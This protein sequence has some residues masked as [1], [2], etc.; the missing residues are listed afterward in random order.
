[1][2]AQLCLVGPFVAFDCEFDSPLPASWSTAADSMA[3]A[4]K[5]KITCIGV[6]G[7]H[8]NGVPFR[9]V[10]A[11]TPQGEAR[12]R[13]PLGRRAIEHFLHYLETM[14]DSGYAIVSWGGT[15][16][17]FRVLAAHAARPQVVVDLCK[18]HVDVP[19]AFLCERGIMFGL[20]AASIGTLGY[21]A[22]DGLT[23]SRD[24]P[25]TWA[26]D[27]DKVMAH[28][29]D[30]AVRTANLFV[31]M[32]MHAK[33][34]IPCVT[35]STY[36]VPPPDGT[37]AWL[38]WITRKGEACASWIAYPLRGVLACAALPKPSAGTCAPRTREECCQWFLSA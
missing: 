35:T 1:M 38:K 3:A 37:V 12:R 13:R 6:S 17:D 15:A 26:R 18:G 23:A 29:Q 8:A 25:Q 10:V 19:F 7:F 4:R 33:M 28:V 20:D 22:A 27:P 24:A 34:G 30:D 14:R 21:G 36:A 32:Q 11:E 31:A 2:A 9:H 5:I 16:A